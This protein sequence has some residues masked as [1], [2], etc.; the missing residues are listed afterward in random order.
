MIIS[1][2]SNEIW[3]KKTYTSEFSKDN[4]EKFEN[5]RAIG[6]RAIRKL[7]SAYKLVISTRA[8][9]KLMSA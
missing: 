5:T 9:R 8:I 1:I 4:D 7:R 3:K 6:T 2:I